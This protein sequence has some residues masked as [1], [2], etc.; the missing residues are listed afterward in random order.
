MKSFLLELK[1]F[2]KGFKFLAFILVLLSY[3]A[4]LLNQFQS[5]EAQAEIYQH[6]LNERYYSESAAFVRYWQ[7][8]LDGGGAISYPSDWVE[9]FLAWYKYETSLGQEIIDSFASRDWDTYNHKMAA[10]RLLEWNIYDKTGDHSSIYSPYISPEQYFAARLDSVEAAIQP[11]W[12]ER[13]PMHINERQK[14]VPTPEQVIFSADLHY[15]LYK[16]G[17]PPVNGYSTTPWAFIFNYL[18]QGLPYVL[19]LIVLLMTVNII[20]RE[21]KFGSIKF[22]LQHPK[23]RS[24]FL[25]RKIGLGF[26]SSLLVV[27]IPQF[28]MFIWLGLQS[29]F[30]G[31]RIPVL[32]E[33][34]FLAWAYHPEHL[35]LLRWTFWFNNVGLSEYASSYT[36]YEAAERLHFVPLWQFLLLSAVFLAVFVLLCAVVG[37]LISILVKNEIFAQVAAVATFA[38]GIAFQNIFPKLATTHWDLFSKANVIPILEGNH[39]STY[40]S[41]LV[42]MVVAIIVLFGISALTFRRQD[43]TTG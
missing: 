8:R 24:V 9:S 18:R 21:R 30:R 16:E 4:M 1:S 11:Q 34:N 38:F 19:S 26:V 35:R 14:T 3:Q 20:H 25:L 15:Q 39:Y 36:G 33:N 5:Q 32:L 31:L 28:I 27:T 17:L 42:A 41:G 37:I 13:L 22:S 7:N 10:K 2:C 23:A 29:G 43:I 40:L 12:F 6:R